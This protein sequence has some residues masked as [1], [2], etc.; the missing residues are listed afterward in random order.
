MKARKKNEIRAEDFEEFYKKRE[1]EKKEIFMTENNNHIPISDEKLFS[2]TE[3]E[4]YHFL[5]QKMQ[6]NSPTIEIPFILERIES[7]NEYFE[8]IKNN[9]TPIDIL[10][11]GGIGNESKKE[12]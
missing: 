10:K 2:L 9:K 12:K 1:I 5:N 6:D 8:K 7:D 3:K 11:K 4:Y